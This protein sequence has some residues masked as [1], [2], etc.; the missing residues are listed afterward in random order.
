MIGD[1]VH[2]G[3]LDEAVVEP[4][5]NSI[6]GWA[7][8]AWLF[9]VWCKKGNLIPDTC[10]STGIIHTNIVRRH[11]LPYSIISFPFSL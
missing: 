7:D 1:S 4:G 10:Q 9:R 6:G 11:L 2:K 5:V 3:R 8:A